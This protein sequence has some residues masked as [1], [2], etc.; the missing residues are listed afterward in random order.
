MPILFSAIANQKVIIEKYAS[1][2]GNFMEIL[3]EV[4]SKLN[5]RN[6]KMTYSHGRY[7]F[8]YI[9]EDNNV[10]FCLTDKSC[11]RSR[12]FLFL[13]QI[14]RKFEVN[15]R[16]FEKVLAEEMYR[17]SEDYNTITIRKGEL[18]E[19][20]SIGVDSS[21]SI[22][23]EKILIVKNEDNLQYTKISCIETKSPEPIV[24]SV[25]YSKQQLMKIV[26]AVIIILTVMYSCCPLPLLL[27]TIVYIL[28]FIV[29]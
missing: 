5:K 9:I 6:D 28:W 7:L 27:I 12:A 19:L 17:Y 21:E 1:C 8:H 23:G 2:E 25:K 20:N 11:Q 22:L 3:E 13:N 24:I 16:E 26:T 15:K 29:R 4:I 14:K 18:D 10:F